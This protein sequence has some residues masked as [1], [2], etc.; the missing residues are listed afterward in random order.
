MKANGPG[1]RPCI[2]VSANTMAPTR[3]RRFYIGKALQ[4]S[5]AEMLQWVFGYGGLPVILPV[6]APDQPEEEYD[7]L[8]ARF[9]A[10]VLTGGEDISPTFYGESARRPEWAGDP[11]RDRWE[12]GLLRAFVRQHKP[13]L[14]I[15]RG[16]QLINVAF[17]G[18]LFQDVVEDGAV[19]R[20]H[21]DPEPYDLLR[22]TIHIEPG[23][24]LHQLYGVLEGVVNTVHH[25]AIRALG[26]GLTPLAR[27]DDGLI[28]AIQGEGS[29][30]LVGVQWHPEWINGDRIAEGCLS[31]QPLFADFM[32]RAGDGAC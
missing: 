12:M 32:R 6:L 17:G 22:H 23:C 2:A 15:C 29:D 10:L 25:Q 9:D 13:V 19:A 1:H 18:S 20:L 24:Y 16:L 28:E 11:Q 3:D 26:E 4:Y 8:A 21:R 27:S 30:Y 31:P 5:E 7:N 14:G